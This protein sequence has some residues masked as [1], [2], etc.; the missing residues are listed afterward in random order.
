MVKEII[1]IIISLY[2][3]IPAYC[4]LLFSGCKS[5]V[6]DDVDFWNK[7]FGR[8]DKSAF[9]KVG[10]LLWDFREF[11]NVVA[12]RIHAQGTRSQTV[13]MILSK[14]FAFLYPG[15]KTL[16]IDTKC[17]GNRLFIQHGFSTIISAESIGEECWI[18]QQVTIGREY[19]SKPRIGNHVRICAGAIIVGDVDIGDNSII[20]AGAVVTK[21]VPSNEILGGVPARFIK[22]VKG[23][24]FGNQKDL[25]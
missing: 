24:S 3:L 17:I 18:N 11:R 20:A 15:E 8:T 12:A 21:N 10:L 19:A 5:V 14:L 25:L 13:N 6:I 16:F 1:K 22:P 9:I 23:D 2:R 4:L 7:L